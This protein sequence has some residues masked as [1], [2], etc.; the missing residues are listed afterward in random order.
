MIVNRQGFLPL[1]E[2]PLPNL[3][4]ICDKIFPVPAGKM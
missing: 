2:K 4:R 1:P 3:Y